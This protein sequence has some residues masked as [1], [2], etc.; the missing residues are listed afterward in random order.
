[1]HAIKL[2]LNIV[3]S[4]AATK[5]SHL[6]LMCSDPGLLSYKWRQT[7]LLLSHQVR[8]TIPRFNRQQK[9]KGQMTALSPR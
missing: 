1:M 2:N 8:G 7:N 9:E 3:E 5:I 6:V 4:S